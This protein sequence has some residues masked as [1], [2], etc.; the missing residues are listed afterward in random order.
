VSSDS[1]RA[2]ATDHSKGPV[3]AGQVDSGEPTA[4]QRNPERGRLPHRSDA[5]SPDTSG[6]LLT[7]IKGTHQQVP[8]VHQACFHR[9]HSGIRI[10][11]AV[12][13]LA[14]TLR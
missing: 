9:P 5:A 13:E 4:G 7:S 8:H 14:L 10:A 11:V 3:G 1:T 6:L 2:D 12:R